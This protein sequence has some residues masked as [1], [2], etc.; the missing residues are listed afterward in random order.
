MLLKTNRAQFERAQLIPRI[1]FNKIFHKRST[2]N[3]TVYL[4]IQNVKICERV[5]DSGVTLDSKIYFNVHFN[6]IFSPNFLSK[7]ETSEEP[8]RHP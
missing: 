6:V 8:K 5:R 2:P 7:K 3:I 4:G 1:Y